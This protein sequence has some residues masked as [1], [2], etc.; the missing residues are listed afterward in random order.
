MTP[1]P[2]ATSACEA[3]VS[4]ASKATF[5][6]KP[7]S[8]QARSVIARQPLRAAAG[9][10]RLVRHV[11]QAQAPAL[12]QRVVGGQHEVVRVVDQVEGLERLASATRAAARSRRSAR[13]RSRRSAAAPWPR[14]ARTRPCSAPR[15]GGARGRPPRRA[16]PAWR[17]RSGSRP[18]AAARRAGP[19]SAASSSS[20]SSIRH[21][22]ASVCA[23]RARPASVR[24]T[25]RAPRSS[26]VV[27]V[28]RSSAATCCEM[29]D[30]VNDSDSAAAENEPRAATSRRTFMRRTSSISPAYR[31]VRRLSFELM[32]LRCHIR[33]WR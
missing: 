14:P 22:I 13:G 5:R 9:D 8:W 28:S 20:A 15:R 24:R 2:A 30:W 3:I 1:T 26:R 19:A 31:G 16:A 18:A 11:G 6:S 23:T 27:P 21:R 32:P 17:P 29:A 33:W 25:P 4:S 7:A 10:P 12:G